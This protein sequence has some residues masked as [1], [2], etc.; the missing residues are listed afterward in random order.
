MA[1]LRDRAAEWS[2]GWA[3]IL[4]T[5]V[6]HSEKRTKRFDFALTR[7]HRVTTRGRNQDTAWAELR[8]AD[9]AVGER[10]RRA[11]RKNSYSHQVVEMSRTTTPEDTLHAASI[12][13]ERQARYQRRMSNLLA[14]RAR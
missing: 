13:D 2:P 5:T 11:M 7:W 6:T 4:I 3:M 8:E 1:S 14:G 12:S 9:V 10:N